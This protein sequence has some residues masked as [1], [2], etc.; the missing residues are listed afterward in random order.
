[1]SPSAKG[2]SIHYA[3]PVL[4]PDTEQIDRN[5]HDEYWLIASSSMVLHLLIEERDDVEHAGIGDMAVLN[6]GDTI[7]TL[8]TLISVI[9]MSSS[10]NSVE[11]GTSDYTI[12]S[13]SG[14]GGGTLK[15]SWDNERVLS[16]WLG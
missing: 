6:P 16:F 1:M 9:M 14:E 5:I 8:S 11:S 3:L 15:D 13:T 7:G 2:T 10:L 12:S 4:V